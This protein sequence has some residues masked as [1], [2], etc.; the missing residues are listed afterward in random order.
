M[1]TQIQNDKINADHTGI[2]TL[3]IDIIGNAYRIENE[4]AFANSMKNFSHDLT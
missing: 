1:F 4:Y 3:Y 2:H